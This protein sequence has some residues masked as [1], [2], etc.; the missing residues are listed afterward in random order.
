[1]STHSLIHNGRVRQDAFSE[2][3]GI[4]ALDS[5]Q[6]ID[7]LRL[8]NDID[9][10]TVASA[11]DR[12]KTILIEFPAFTDGRGFSVARLLR[13]R[14]GFTGLLVA[15]GELIPDQYAFALQCGFDA[16]RV[17]AAR[18]NRQPEADWQQG[19]ADF[20]MTYQRGYAVKAGP[21]TAV[22]DARMTAFEGLKK[23]MNSTDTPR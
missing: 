23:T 14:H 6:Q 9:L 4:D 17:D 16:V 3:V 1:M 7:V 5:N 10:S 22:F 18:T 11:L 19:L 8:P 12:V 13:K 20:G 15:D 2:S 21:A